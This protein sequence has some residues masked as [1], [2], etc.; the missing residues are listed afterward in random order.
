MKRQTKDFIKLCLAFLI[1][2]TFTLY[3][4][5]Q[6]TIAALIIARECVGVSK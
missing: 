1:I 5:F 4:A 3:Q 2:L 6:P